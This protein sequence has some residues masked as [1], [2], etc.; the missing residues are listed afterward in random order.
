MSLEFQQLVIH[1][2]S[3]QKTF[4]LSN[5]R[6]QHKKMLAQV[7]QSALLLRVTSSFRTTTRHSHE[8][9]W[10]FREI[11]HIIVIDG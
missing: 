5:Y 11:A 2:P 9:Q 3:M 1:S 8:S 4:K 10:K 7:K 6:K